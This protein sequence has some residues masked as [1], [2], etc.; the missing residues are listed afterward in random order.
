ME[1][2]ME[3]QQVLVSLEDEVFYDCIRELEPFL[4]TGWTAVKIERDTETNTIFMTLE[5]ELAKIA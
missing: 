5:K 1:N 2:E 3:Y 4:T